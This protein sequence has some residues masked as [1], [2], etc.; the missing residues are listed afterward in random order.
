M[1]MAF[2]GETE[3]G[4]PVVLNKK[5][6]ESDLVIYVNLNLVPMDGG[7]KSVAVGLC[8]YESLKAHHNPKVMRK[9]HSYMDPKTSELNTIVERMGKVTNKVLK[10]FT[11]ETTVNNRMFDGRCRSW[12]KNEDDWTGNERLAF[13]GVQFALDRTPT[14]RGRRSSPKVPSPFELTGV[15]AGETE[16]VHKHTLKRCFEQYCV[17]VEGQ[18]DILVCGIPYISPYN[19]NAFLNPLLVQV[20]AQGYLF[21][22]YRNQPLVKKGGTMIITHPCTDRFDHAQHAPYVEFVHRLLPETR[23]A[24]ELHK[25]FEAEF[26]AT[27]RTCRCTAG[28]RVPPGAPVL[29]VVLGRGRA[30]ARGPR[31]RGGRRQRVHPAGARL[32]DRAVDARGAGDGEGHGAP[33]RR[34]SRACT[35]RPS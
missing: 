6:V 25:R 12:H 27:R 34:R 33:R 29:H 28:Q 3:L 23:D 2:V 30:A 13:K 18:A 22:M 20:M 19:V 5:A 15:F 35:C 11:I 32:R 21:N 17:P 9:C 7:H 26:A 4:E 10:V 16:A 31:H 24:M 8:G 1:N 14:R